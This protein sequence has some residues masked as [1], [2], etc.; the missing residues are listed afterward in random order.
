[1]K[2]LM[3]LPQYEVDLE[4]SK[5]GKEG[6]GFKLLSMQEADGSW[7][8]TAWN[9][10]W[11]STMHIMTLLKLIELNPKSNEAVNAITLVKNGVVWRGDA[12]FEGNPYFLG[13]IEPCINGQVALSA[14]YFGVDVR[15]IIEQLINQQLNDGGW[16]CDAHLG[17]TKSSFH[18]TICVLEALLEYEKKF[19]S[20]LKIT[21]SRLV[22][23]EY[24]LKRK[25]YKRLSTGEAIYSD[26]KTKNNHNNASLFTEIAFPTWWHYDILRALEY[27]RNSA[28][29]PDLRMHEAINILKSKRQ[30]DGCWLTELEYPGNM[31]IQFNSEVG[32][33]S[34]WITLY[35]LRII[36]WYDGV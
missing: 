33:S 31:P 15:E 26:R 35:A 17:S 11:N 20:N 24:L 12:A 29:K 22:G 30:S 23:E 6:F 5:I 27:F 8:G 16:N 25:L 34:K 19:G 7:S 4:H 18:T 13:E 10:G 32:Q 28:R 3:N 2:D 21:N 14:A 36:K 9:H 1:M